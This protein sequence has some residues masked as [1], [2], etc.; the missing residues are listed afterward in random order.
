M[1]WNARGLLTTLKESGRPDD[2]GGI[3]RRAQQFS[4]DSSGLLTT[5]TTRDAQYHYQRNNSGQLTG[6][7]RTPTADGVALGIEQD[8]IQFTFDAAGKPLSERGINGELHYNY[9]ALDNLTALTLPGGQQISWLHYGSGHVSAIRFNQQIISEF[10]RNRLHREISR[11][12]GIREQT[13]QY[14]SLGRRT[15]QRGFAPDLPEQTIFERAFTYTARGELSD[16]SDTLRGHTIYGYDEEGR[17]LR[18]YEAR[19]G[20][21]NRTF[22]YDGAC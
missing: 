3:P 2:D 19:P 16:V 9:D 22:R 7:T 10:T 21:S 17:F 4:Y 20:H 11:T 18:H 15:R 1:E 14:D 6:L 8:E 12:Q 5:R 13:R